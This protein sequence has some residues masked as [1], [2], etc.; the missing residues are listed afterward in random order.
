MGRFSAEP[1][2][3]SSTSSEAFRTL[4]GTIRSV[5]PDAIVAPYLVV[6]VTDARHYSALSRNVFRFLP[7]RLTS[8]DLERI[9]GMDERIGVSEYEA[10][11]RTYH[12]LAIDFTRG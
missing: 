7:L 4:E 2:A 8:A 11:I 1:S 9:H 3:V 12:Q 5:V 6:V 10:A